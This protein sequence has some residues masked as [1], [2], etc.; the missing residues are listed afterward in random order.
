MTKQKEQEIT[1]AEF[2]EWKSSRVTQRLFE[3]LEVE[4]ET[5]RINMVVNRGTIHER[6]VASVKNGAMVDFAE[7]L[8]TMNVAYLNTSIYMEEE[9]AA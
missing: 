5:A 3:M 1:E 2:L 8:V 7:Y 6:G 9:D 4:I